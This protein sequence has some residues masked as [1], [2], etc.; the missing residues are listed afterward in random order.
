MLSETPATLIQNPDSEVAVRDAFGI[1]SDL[2]VPAFSEPT[3]LVPALEST[4]RFDRDTTLA[5]L[6]GFAHNRRVLIQGYHGTG[7]STHIEQVA[8]RLNWP[9]VRIN[10][11]SHISRIDLI[12][13]DAIVIRDGHQITEFRDGMLPWAAQN[14]VALV[15][16]EYDAGR[17]DV[18]FVIH[19]VLEVEGKLTLLDQ[20]RVIHPHPFFRLFAT[21]N[22]IGLGD[23]TGLYQGTQ[24]IN[25]GQLDR[26]NIVATLNYLDSAAEAAIVTARVPSYASTA[27]Q[28]TVGQMVA[29]A[30]L[31][32]QGFTAG[33]LST[34]MSPRTVINWAENAEIFGNVERAF[35]LTFLNKC[36]EAEQ[37]AVAEYY[38]RCFD[39]ELDKSITLLAPPSD[40]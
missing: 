33:D 10:L 5:I 14:P 18:M 31:T 22:T 40:P 2:A 29:M 13:K 12:G 8:A 21:A 3:D 38:Q 39:V 28:R 15:F 6:A 26:W 24:P 27:G 36:D 16:D 11:D 7:K 17:P 35:C 34:V 19:R 25:Q 32:R 23:A 4:Y 30:N 20:S 9:C 1:D 37:P